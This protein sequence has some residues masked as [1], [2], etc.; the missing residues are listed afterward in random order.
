MHRRADRGR[1]QSAPGGG[2]PWRFLK[3]LGSCGRSR[4]AREGGERGGV[5]GRSRSTSPGNEPW[6]GNLRRLASQR[7]LVRKTAPRESREPPPE[8]TRDV[9]VHAVDTSPRL[10]GE[11]KK[12]SSDEKMCG[13]VIALSTGMIPK[14]ECS[15]PPTTE[16]PLELAVHMRTVAS[17]VSTPLGS[18]SRNMESV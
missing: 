3:V 13:V 2:D 10:Y 5:H 17:E 15:V 4:R 11:D 7:S 1:A 16:L 6:K 12:G 18:H 14:A 9:Q 8:V